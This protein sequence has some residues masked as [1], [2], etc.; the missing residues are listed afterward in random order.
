M[1]CENCLT[2]TKIIK[3][4]SQ[5]QVKR[6]HKMLT[7]LFKGD[8]HLN[9]NLLRLRLQSTEYSGHIDLCGEGTLDD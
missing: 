8:T 2:R 9:S 7:F 6:F 1:K 4:D 3:N 5:L